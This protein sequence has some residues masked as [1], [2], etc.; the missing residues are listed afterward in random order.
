MTLEE[1]KYEHQPALVMFLNASVLRHWETQ[2]DLTEKLLNQMSVWYGK[3]ALSPIH[4]EMQNWGQEKYIEGGPVAVFGP[5]AISQMDQPLNTPVG[6]IF[7]AGTEFATQS[8][9]YMDGAIQSGKL[10]VVKLLA[11][12]A[13]EN[14]SEFDRIFCFNKVDKDF[15]KFECSFEKGN[16]KC[17]IGSNFKTLGKQT[18]VKY[19]IY[20]GSKF[21]M[22]LGFLIWG[23]VVLILC[24]IFKISFF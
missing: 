6:R 13:K 22:N 3:E 17:K 4:I 9:G 5:G 14:D 12:S 24:L 2:P 1:T 10:A 11:F 23:M 16:V 19:D 18:E 20:Q 15:E 8:Q 7:F 21:Q